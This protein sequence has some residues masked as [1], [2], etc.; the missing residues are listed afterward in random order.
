MNFS[1]NVLHLV[2]VQWLVSPC[3]RS[4]H[5]RWKNCSLDLGGEQSVSGCFQLL[6]S[7]SN[8]L[9]LR[10]KLSPQHFPG[11]KQP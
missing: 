3:P 6:E 9:I 4:A 8:L 5:V 2:P 10:C 1:Q 7:H 11:E